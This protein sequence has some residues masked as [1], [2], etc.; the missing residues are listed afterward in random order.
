MMRSMGYVY[1]Y[2]S[3]EGNIFKIGRSIDYD[4][5]VKA[6]ATGNSEPLTQFVLNGVGR[7]D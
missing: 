1:I 3:G 2:R 6:H 5:R 7:Y 4:R